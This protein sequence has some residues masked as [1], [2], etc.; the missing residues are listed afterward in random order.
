MSA[1]RLCQLTSGS[2]NERMS[3]CSQ[4]QNTSWSTSKPPLTSEYK[5]LLVIVINLVLK[6]GWLAA[7]KI[8][9]A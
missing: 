5:K 4:H 2:E 7:L 9:H 3:N 8:Q 6:S 1:A